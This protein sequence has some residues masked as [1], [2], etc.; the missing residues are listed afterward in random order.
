MSEAWRARQSAIGEQ[1]APVEIGGYAWE[2]DSNFAVAMANAGGM[3]IEAG[4]PGTT[5][6]EVCQYWTTMG[7]SRFPRVNTDSR[8]PP[9]DG[10]PGK[11]S[12]PVLRAAPTLLP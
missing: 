2:P 6:P 10:G 11:T 8:P 5:P 12:S 3:Q 7:N 9:P 4:G 1:T